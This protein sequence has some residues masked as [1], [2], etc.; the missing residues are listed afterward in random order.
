MSAGGEAGRPERYCAN[1]GAQ[2]RPGIA[3]CVSCGER[4]DIAH[5]ERATAS[6]SPWVTASDSKGGGLLSQREIWLAMYAAGVLVFLVVIYLVLRY[7]VALGV[8]LVVLSVFAVAVVRRARGS[9]MRPEQ[10]AFEKAVRYNREFIQNAYR[11][12]RRAYQEVSTRHRRWSEHQAAERERAKLLGK[13]EL[14]RHKRRVELERYVN[15][16]ERAHKGSQTSLDWWQA[17]EDKQSDNEQPSTSDL[18]RSARDQ[19]EVRLARAKGL[20]DS[21]ADLLREESFIEVDRL[22]AD[23][24]TGQENLEG[25]ES[26]FPPLVA[27]HNRVKRLD[28]WENYRGELEKFIRDLEDLLGSPAVRTTAANR[29]RFPKPGETRPGGTVEQHSTDSYTKVGSDVGSERF[30][31]L[32]RTSMSSNRFKGGVTESD[33]NRIIGSSFRGAATKD[34]VNLLA[35]MADF[36]ASKGYWQRT[37]PIAKSVVTHVLGL[38]SVLAR[39]DGRVDK[40]EL[41]VLGDLLREI[42]GEDEDHRH[43]KDRG[44]L[45]GFEKFQFEQARG[46]ILSTPDYICAIVAYDKDNGTTLSAAVLLVLGEIGR[47]MITADRY[48]GEDEVATLTKHI[49]HLRWYIESQGVSADPAEEANEA[50]TDAE[51][52][53]QKKAQDAPTIDELLAKLHRLVGLSGVKQEVETLTNLIRVRQERMEKALRVPP[54]S[55]HLVFTGNPGTGKTTVA[56]LLASIYQSLGLLSKGHLVEVDRSGLVA[57]YM[58]Q[59]AIKVQEVVKSALG[60]VLFIDEAYSLVSG[61]HESD[62]GREAVDT[63]LKAMEDHRDDLVIIVAGY[64]KKMAEFLQSNPGL[65]SRFNRFIHFEDYSPT[66]MYDIFERICEDYGYRLTPAATAHVRTMFETM[67]AN[68]GA[69]FGNAR[70]VRNVFERAVSSHANRIAKLS[71]SGERDLSTLDVADFPPLSVL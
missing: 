26:V 44:Y 67:D 4:I 19:A 17:Y 70:E 46:L 8:L 14:E 34:L 48:V 71:D 20:E 39:A 61:R 24:R 1:C 47:R 52:K 65:Q 62:Y 29:I 50:E 28:G 68:R 37:E 22:L 6:A 31:T 53:E 18:L 27:V 43:L 36:I 12:S 25:E 11:Q 40:Y 45:R 42:L 2:V 41:D 64:P 63:L 30:P 49:A 51:V 5:E 10:Q 55:F 59:T 60:G 33:L 13:I 7:S 54:M 16:F 35:G 21:L 56:R 38:L 32:H 58:G 69:N 3:F 66:E 9:Q 57:A 23:L 15:F